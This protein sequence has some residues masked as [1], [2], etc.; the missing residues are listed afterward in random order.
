[1]KILT[2]RVKSMVGCNL[3]VYNDIC[4]DVFEGEQVMLLI[5]TIAY[6]LL[7]AFESLIVV[8]HEYN[9]CSQPNI[10]RNIERGSMYL[11]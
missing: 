9:G 2:T 1:M 11:S 7:F 3:H 10:I 5:F 8:A 4:I 6:G